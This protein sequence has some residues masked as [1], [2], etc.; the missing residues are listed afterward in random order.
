MTPAEFATAMKAI[1]TEYRGDPEVAHMMADDL[2]C[3][4]LIS[5][6]YAE[7]VMAYTAMDKWYA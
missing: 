1:P 5:L 7:G 6:G 3:Q 2:L 4:V